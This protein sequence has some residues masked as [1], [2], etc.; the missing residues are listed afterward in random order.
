MYTKKLIAK[1]V[2]A[3]KALL[4]I[5]FKMPLDLFEVTVST[6]NRKI[7]RVMNVS[8]API[9]GCGN[10]SKCMYFCYDIKAV[11][12]YPNVIYAR[13]KNLMI[14]QRDRAKYFGEIE[15]KINRRRK[16]KYFRWHV[17]GDILD[18]EYFVKMVAIAKRHPDFVFWTYTKMYSIVN[19]YVV[20][21]GGSKQAAI[22]E[23]LH[24]MFSE[25][26]GMPLNNPY[27]FPIFTVKFKAGNINHEPEFFN[28][29]YKCPGNCDLCKAAKKGCIGGQDTY[30]DEH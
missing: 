18:Y 19:E 16:N 17:A 29:L 13:I 8:T 5:M 20:K 28:S 6:G 14:A 10:C 24:I 15:N 25:W 9:L 21:N 26:D 3:M 1:V 12:Q 7:G 2:A 4:A 22:P 30:C 27:S 23:N 11:N